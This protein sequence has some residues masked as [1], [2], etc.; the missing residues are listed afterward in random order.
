MLFLK[1]FI[2]KSSPSLG[3]ALGC[4]TEMS[5]LYIVLYARNFSSIKCN[6]TIWLEKKMHIQMGRLLSAAKGTLK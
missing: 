6:A 4:C 2:T 1:Q 3:I 5:F